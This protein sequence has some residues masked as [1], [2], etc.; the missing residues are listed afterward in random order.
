MDAFP[1]NI[2]KDRLERLENLGAFFK[3]I[4]EEAKGKGLQN[5]SDDIE[6]DSPKDRLE[7]SEM[8]MFLHMK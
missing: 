2:D 4:S 1:N 6:L 7:T 8:V 3:T 5:L